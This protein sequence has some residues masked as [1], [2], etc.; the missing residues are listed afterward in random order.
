MSPAMNLFLLALLSVSVVACYNVDPVKCSNKI[1]KSNCFLQGTS[2]ARQTMIFTATFS[3][4]KPDTCIQCLIKSL[5]IASWGCTLAEMLRWCKQR[6]RELERQL[7]DSRVE[8]KLGSEKEVKEMH[9]FD[10]IELKELKTRMHKGLASFATLLAKFDLA[11]PDFTQKESKI[12]DGM[13]NRQSQQISG[14][15]NDCIVF[16][17]PSWLTHG[18]HS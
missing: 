8:N 12:M 5:D 1:G 10:Q 17:R 15:S 14:P 3:K 2:K 16:R 4:K 13:V 6:E 7:D 18:N 9:K 11:H